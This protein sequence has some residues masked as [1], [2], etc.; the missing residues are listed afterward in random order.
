VKDKE[1][2]SKQKEKREKGMQVA[3]EGRNAIYDTCDGDLA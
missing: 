1:G 3:S 2:G